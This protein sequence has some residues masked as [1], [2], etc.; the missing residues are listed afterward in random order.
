[1][2]TVS[3]GRRVVDGADMKGPFGKKNLFYE[4]MSLLIAVT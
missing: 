4:S 2:C 3:R 1:M